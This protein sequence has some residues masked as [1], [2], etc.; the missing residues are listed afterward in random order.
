[1]WL[2]RPNWWNDCVVFH[3]RSVFKFKLGI[4]R[5]CFK[6]TVIRSVVGKLVLESQLSNSS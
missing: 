6:D 3:E 1:M 5:M 4:L 2:S